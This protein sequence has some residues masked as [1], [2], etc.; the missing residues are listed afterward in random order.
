MRIPANAVI[1]Y[2]PL[3]LIHA[4]V[5]EILPPQSC[6]ELDFVEIAFLHNPESDH[7]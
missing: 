6:M 7:A 3:V 4:P 5:A 2:T 1:P